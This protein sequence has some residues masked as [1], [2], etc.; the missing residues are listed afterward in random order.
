MKCHRRALFSN[1]ITG[2]TYVHKQEAH[3]E[4]KKVYHVSLVQVMVDYIGKNKPNFS[5]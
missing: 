4:G 3:N 1:F 5:G 2:I